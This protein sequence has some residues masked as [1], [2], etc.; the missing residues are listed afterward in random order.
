M[1][2]A[3]IR[4]STSSLEG[5]LDQPLVLRSLL[6]GCLRKRGGSFATRTAPVSV[7]ARHGRVLERSR[8]RGPAGSEHAREHAFQ[9]LRLTDRSPDFPEMCAELLTADTWHLVDYGR[10]VWDED[11]LLIETRSALRAVQSACER[12]RNARKLFLHDNLALVLLLTRRRTRSFLVLAVI[13]RKYGIA[14][15]ANCLFFQWVPSD[16]NYS[17]RASRFYDADYDFSKCFFNRLRVC[18]GNPCRHILLTKHRL[19]REFHRPGQCSSTPVSRTP[20][21][22]VSVIDHPSDAT[23]S[24]GLQLSVRCEFF[25]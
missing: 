13:R 2:F 19:S 12:H 16:V 24:R 11:I 25:W 7:V 9:Y 22:T 10:F 21:T 3:S 4:Q 17:D 23:A 20:P 8:F 18:S 1:S 5:R 14:Y 6:L 15:R